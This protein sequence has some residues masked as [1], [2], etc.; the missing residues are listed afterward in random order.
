[1]RPGHLRIDEKGRLKLGA[2]SGGITGLEQQIAVTNQSDD[3]SWIELCRLTV[4]LPRCRQVTAGM[5]QR[6]EFG[7]GYGMPGIE[8]QRVELGLAGCRII[9]LR[10]QAARPK[11]CRVDHVRPIRMGRCW[12]CGQPRPQSDQRIDAAAPGV[13]AGLRRRPARLARLLR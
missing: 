6:A 5:R 3:A 13:R 10:H 9:A 4:R 12:K 11:Q 1:M 8:P 7:Q 2:G